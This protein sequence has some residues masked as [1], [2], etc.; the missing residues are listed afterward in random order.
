MLFMLASAMNRDVFNSIQTLNGRHFTPK[1]MGM[2]CPSRPIKSGGSGSGFC[3][4][5]DMNA[6]TGAGVGACVWG[7]LRAV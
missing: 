6:L 5:T 7:A 1:I 3:F 2:L 4:D